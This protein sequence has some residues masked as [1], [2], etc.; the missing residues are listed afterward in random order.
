MCV[1]MDWEGS[2]LQNPMKRKTL[3]GSVSDRPIREGGLGNFSLAGRGEYSF[4]NT[5]NILGCVLALHAQSLFH[6]FGK[7]YCCLILKMKQLSFHL[8]HRCGPGYQ[9]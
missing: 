1:W 3:K 5:Y 9:S 8:E 6:P 7:G 4:M 2:C